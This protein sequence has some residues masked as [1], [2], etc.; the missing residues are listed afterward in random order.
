MD[1]WPR[2]SEEEL[3]DMYEDIDEMART[4]EQELRNH[5]PIE[6]TPE[7]RI[8]F[9]DATPRTSWRRSTPTTKP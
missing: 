2:P 5:F 6:E 9:G 8:Q 3:P 7:E 4:A 1:D